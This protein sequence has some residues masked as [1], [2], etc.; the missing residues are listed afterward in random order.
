MAGVAGGV[1]GVLNRIRKRKGVEKPGSGRVQD[2]PETLKHHDLSFSLSVN[3]L[4]LEKAIPMTNSKF[5]MAVILQLGATMLI[6]DTFSLASTCQSVCQALLAVS[7]TIT[8]KFAKD[9]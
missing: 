9:M 3:K 2:S 5:E 6:I 4:N 7:F 1:G 8:V